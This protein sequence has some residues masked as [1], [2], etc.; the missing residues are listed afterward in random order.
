MMTRSRGTHGWAWRDGLTNRRW[1]HEEFDDLD[2]DRLAEKVPGGTPASGE[3]AAAQ[4]PTWADE[5]DYDEPGTGGCC[6]E[7]P[8][9]FPD[10]RILMSHDWEK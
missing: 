10:P 2:R 9:S 4:L 7:R 8:S 6:G 5:A 3:D 1:L